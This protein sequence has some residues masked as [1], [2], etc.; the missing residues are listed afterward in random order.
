MWMSQMRMRCVE[1][2]VQVDETGEGRLSG[3]PGKCI[4]AQR[5]ASHKCR[6]ES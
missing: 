5:Q 2:G 3:K 1:G 6:K 4:V